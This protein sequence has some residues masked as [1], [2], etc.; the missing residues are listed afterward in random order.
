MLIKNKA[1]RMIC[2]AAAF[3]LWTGASAQTIDRVPD[4]F[5][6]VLSASPRVPGASFGSQTVEITADGAVWLS[7]VRTPEGELLAVDLKISPAAVERI[8]QAVAKHDFFNLQSEYRD[9]E[10]YDGD[11]AALTVW[12]G[13]RKHQ[14]KTV[15]IRV[16]DFDLITVA[17]NAELP[18]DRVIVY[19]ALFIPEYKEVQR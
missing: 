2:L 9:P 16:L 7:A 6:I 14:V 11:F 19:N 8:W 15:N 18:Q 13:Q 3:V 4:D 12:A 5:K 1:C 17:V 10:I